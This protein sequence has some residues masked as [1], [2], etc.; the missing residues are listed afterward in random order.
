MLRP[1]IINSELY[2]TENF[3]TDTPSD[4]PFIHRISDESRESDGTGSKNTTTLKHD[5]TISNP[6]TEDENWE[7]KFVNTIL[8]K[9]Q[10]REEEQTKEKFIFPP[11]EDDELDYLSDNLDGNQILVEDSRLLQPEG[12]FTSYLIR[13]SVQKNQGVILKGLS[14]VYSTKILKY[15]C[16][17]ELK[18]N[19]RVLGRVLHNI[20]NTIDPQKEIEFATSVT[21][22]PIVENLVSKIEKC[23][24]SADISD[25]LLPSGKYIKNLKEQLY[26]A[27][28]KWDITRTAVIFVSRRL[29]NYE[30]LSDEEADAHKF[31]QRRHYHMEVFS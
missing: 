15:A 9:N 11:D 23:V 5:Q 24:S 18:N 4:P 10:D 25:T 21:A 26:N 12:G 8:E 16:I 31:A 29:V 1:G 19:P 22:R 27:Y 20:Q 30:G 7:S 6:N 3:K 17:T 14:S 28:H 13:E 2:L